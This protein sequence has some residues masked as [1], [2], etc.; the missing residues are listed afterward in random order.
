MNPSSVALWSIHAL[1]Y[2]KLCPNYACI[3][4]SFVQEEC[5]Q[6]TLAQCSRVEMV[7][8]LRCKRGLHWAGTELEGNLCYPKDAA[9]PWAGSGAGP[10]LRAG[11]SPPLLCFLGVDEKRKATKWRKCT[12]KGHEQ[13][14]MLLWS[15]FPVKS[16][17]NVFKIF[18][19]E[20]LCSAQVRY[21]PVFQISFCKN[22]DYILIFDLR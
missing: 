11:I 8:V 2:G 4:P 13:F 1:E 6:N 10:A 9:S 20:H 22:S 16:R 18:Q 15:D 21:W 3:W 19:N 14:Y 12:A 17:E 5:L 7:N